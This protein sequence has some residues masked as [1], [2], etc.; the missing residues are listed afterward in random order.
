M[1][2]G[3]AVLE[4]VDEMTSMTEPFIE[5]RRERRDVDAATG[6]RNGLIVE[7]LAILVLWVVWV[8]VR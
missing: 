5:R 4:S 2:G 8:V 1:A 6:V 3:R 7:A